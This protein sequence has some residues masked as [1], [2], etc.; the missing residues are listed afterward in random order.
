MHLEKAEDDFRCRHKG[1]ALLAP[2]ARGWVLLTPA[3]TAGV[4]PGSFLSTWK[5]GSTLALRILR[6]QT[7]TETKED[8]FALIDGLH[9][10]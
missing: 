6:C 3:L 1:A 5:P 9:S 7:F 10:G 2:G 4:N 8:E